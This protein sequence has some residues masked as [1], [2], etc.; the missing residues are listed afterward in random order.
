MR[1]AAVSFVLFA[2][3]SAGGAALADT[4]DAGERTHRHALK[5][6]ALGEKREIFVRTPPNYRGGPLPVVYVTDAEWNFEL[7]AARFDFLIDNGA[8]PPVVVTGVRNVNRNRD[9][10]PRADP[11]YDDSGGAESFLAFVREEWAPFVERTYSG[12]GDRVLI[13]HSFG[14][15]FALHA[16]FAAPGFFDA[17][18]SLSPSAWVA[19]RVLFEEASAM[20]AA[21]PRLRSFAYIAVGEGDGGP[22]RPSTEAL[23]ELF[24][25]DAPAGLAWT[26]RIAPQADHFTNFTWGLN[27]GL[28]AAFPQWGDAE[29]VRAA[30]ESAGAD[31]VARW[32]DEKEAA[33]GFRFFPSWFDFGIAAIRLSRTERADAAIALMDRTRRYHAENANFAAFSAQVYENAGAFERAIGEYQRAIAIARRD[34]LHPNAIHIDRLEAGIARIRETAGAATP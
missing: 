21:E 34:G 22:T 18:L 30:G 1:H 24:A 7:V 13:G 15:V 5:S 17:H 10:L 4:I 27:D 28:M 3:L 9:F 11:D 25:A 33:L 26:L 31:G 8:L 20:F 23:G 6:A 16:L 14:G 32:F 29:A 19:D 12:T 2:A